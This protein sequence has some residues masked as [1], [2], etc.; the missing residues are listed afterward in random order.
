MNPP[1]VAP[2]RRNVLVGAVS[3]AAS[4]A[5]AALP[6]DGRLAFAAL[7]N[8]DRVGEHVMTFTRSGSV[9][10][11]VTDTTMRIA[12]GP[13]PL[14]RYAHEAEEVWKDG[15]FER[16][17]TSSS[18]N[19]KRERVLAVR[20]G[21]KVRIETGS[22]VVTASG[23]AAPLTHWNVEALDRPLFNPQTGELLDVRTRRHPGERLPPP[24]RG[25][26]TRWTVRGDAEIDNWYGESGVWA[27]LRG[28]LPDGSELEYRP[29]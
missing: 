27:A 26:A 23:N 9:L 11:V 8:G 21:G 6:A 1:I 14:F 22:G 24:Q 18:S 2:T 13:I 5:F 28:R 25:P 4:P 12:L 20:Q 10:K 19:G 29:V 17:K 7:R 3:L 15:R 16:L